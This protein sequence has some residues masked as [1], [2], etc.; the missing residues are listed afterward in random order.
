MKISHGHFKTSTNTFFFL[1]F[2]HN[3]FVYIF[4]HHRIIILC[5]YT[6]IQKQW[7]VSLITI[8]E[9]FP[10]VSWWF[11]ASFLQCYFYAFVCVSTP[12]SEAATIPMLLIMLL[13]CEIRVFPYSL[14]CVYQPDDAKRCDHHL[15]YTSFPLA[16]SYISINSHRHWGCSSVHVYTVF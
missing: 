8:I 10:V 2:F 7:R 13:V 12:S 6:H 3:H 4:S 11:P 14:L 15:V 1:S 9:C 5:N 16:F